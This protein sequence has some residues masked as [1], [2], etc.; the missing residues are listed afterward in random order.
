MKRAMTLV[1]PG[2]ILKQEIEGRGLSVTDA[3]QI[4]EVTRPNLSNIIN[5][6]TSISPLMALKLESKFGGSARLWMQLQSTYDL[7]IARKKFNEELEV[8]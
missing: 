1:H 3:A 6:K 4:L 8:A 5:E 7:D 2:A